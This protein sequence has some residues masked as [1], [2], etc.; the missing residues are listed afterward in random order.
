MGHPSSK[1]TDS[2]GATG[3]NEF[4]VIVDALPEDHSLSSRDAVCLADLEGCALVL[5]PPGRPHRI[6]LEASLAGI[7]WT[8]AAEVQ[9]W[10]LMLQLVG[11]GLG[12]AFVNAFVPRP[13]G[14]VYRR[15]EGLKPVTYVLLQRALAP[16]FPEVDA[17]REL[18]L[19]ET[20]TWRA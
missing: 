19:E 10:E 15:V 3:E 7:D 20:A 2:A 9:G 8:V 16:R 14:V 17:L 6:R 11:L 13:E 12:A 5:P 18:L 1:L 4:G